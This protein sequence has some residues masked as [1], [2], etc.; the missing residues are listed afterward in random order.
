MLRPT[1]A[2]FRPSLWAERTTSRKRPM[3]EANVVTSTRPGADQ[4]LERF[5]HAGF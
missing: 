1:T 4:L 2:A 3:F 5:A